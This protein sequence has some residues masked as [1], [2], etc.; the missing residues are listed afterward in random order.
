M[1]PT[2]EAWI[3]KKPGLT[4][5]WIL[6]DYTTYIY[7]K[8]PGAF[9]SLQKISQ[10]C[11]K[12]K[13]SRLPVASIFSCALAITFSE[14]ISKNHGYSIHPVHRK[15]SP[16]SRGNSQ[17]GTSCFTSS[18]NCC[19]F[20]TCSQVPDMRRT[21]VRTPTLLGHPIGGVKTGNSVVFCYGTLRKK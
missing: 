20:R 12:R 4:F 3:R 17:I 21:N 5:H 10:N 16:T 6:A 14:G 11:P 8:Q 15:K 18:I 13:L 1:R 9:F 19:I 7:T 2:F